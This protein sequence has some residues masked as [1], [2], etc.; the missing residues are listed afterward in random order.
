MYTRGH[1][2]ISSIY[3]LLHK[4]ITAGTQSTFHGHSPRAGFTTV[5]VLLRGAQNG[6][7]YFIILFPSTELPVSLGESRKLAQ[8]FFL[9]TGSGGLCSTVLRGRIKS[10]S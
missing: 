5:I 1:V 2:V 6:A 8:Q 10:L 4:I 9:S 7:S 3:S